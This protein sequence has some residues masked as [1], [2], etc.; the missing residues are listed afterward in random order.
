MPSVIVLDCRQFA[1]GMALSM[2]SHLMTAQFLVATTQAALMDLAGPHYNHS[3]SHHRL[4]PRRLMV[5][6]PPQPKHSLILQPLLSAPHRSISLMVI[7]HVMNASVSVTLPQERLILNIGC[8]I[9]LL[10]VVMH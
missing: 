2:Y 6:L 9:K 4:P 8:T 10:L 3:V 1:V 5:L 7:V